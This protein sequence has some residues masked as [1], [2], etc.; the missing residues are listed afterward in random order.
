MNLTKNK[1]QI[2]VT[3]LFLGF[4]AW[5]ISFQTVVDKQGLSVQWFGG[6]YG[7][8]ALIGAL[9]GFFAAR[10][11]GGFKTVLGKALM[12]FSFGLLAQEAGQLIYTYY[13]YAAK[14]DIPYPSWG[15]VAY[16]GSVVLYILAAF[17]L[18]KA[19]GAKFSLKEAKYK[20]VAVIIPVALLAISYWVLLHGHQYDSSK[21]L[22]VFLDFGYPF[23]QAIYISIAITAYL[24]SRKL[25]G[26]LMRGGIVLVIL[27]LF[28]QYIA[29][30]SFVYQSSRGSYVAGKYV[31]LLY[32][33]A[34]F[35]MATAMIK[36]HTIYKNIRSKSETPKPVAEKAE[37][38]S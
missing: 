31:D 20:A 3:L 26:G 30:F 2:L 11:W 34:Y 8:V 23:G 7:V 35:A 15:D 22:T 10:K 6:T 33:V 27:A 9:I 5:W 17:F 18:A 13:V 37:A 16:F 21:P 28:V 25:L 19:A 24:L 38:G 32:L 14:I 36:F 1:L 12:F 29:D 4:F